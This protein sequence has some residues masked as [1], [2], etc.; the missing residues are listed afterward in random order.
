MVLVEGLLRLACRQADSPFAFANTHYIITFD[1][2]AALI[3]L[4]LTTAAEVIRTLRLCSRAR[5][6]L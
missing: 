5:L 2:M 3:D 6:D 1:L 4:I